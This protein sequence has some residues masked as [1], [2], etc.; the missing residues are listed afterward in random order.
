[1]YNYNVYITININSR[2]KKCLQ[3]D[4]FRNHYLLTKL[5]NVKVKHKL[6]DLKF[7]GL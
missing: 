7:K 2:G 4:T 1:M 5:K 6:R 3:H